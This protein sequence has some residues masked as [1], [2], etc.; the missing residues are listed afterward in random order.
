MAQRLELEAL[1]RAL[2]GSNNVYFQPPPS[3]QM[4]YDCIVYARDNSSTDFADN[5]PYRNK[6][7]YQVTVITKDPDSDIPDKVEALRLCS[8]NRAFKADQLNHIVF[9]L[10][11]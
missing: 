6:K 2:L 3:V 11:F 9:N 1:L 4:E 7:R 10:F 8:F 5:Q